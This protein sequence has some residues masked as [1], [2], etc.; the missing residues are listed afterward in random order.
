MRD[1]AP[2]GRRRAALTS[3]QLTAS[4][5]ALTCSCTFAQ[6]FGP[7]ACSLEPGTKACVDATPCKTDTSG[8]QICLSTVTSPPS[9]ALTIAQT[10]WQYG[11]TFA[12]AST[13][14]DTCKPY[15]T[16]PACSVISSIC[17]DHMVPSG[18]CDSW[19]FTYQCETAPGPTS[20]TTTCTTGLFDSSGFAALPKTNNNMPSAAVAEEMIREGQLYSDKGSNLFAGVS[21]TCRKGYGGL[22]SCCKSAPGAKTN[23]QVSEVAFGAAAQ[24]VKYLGE[25]AIDWASP[26]VLDSMYNNG[27]WIAGMTE[28]FQTGGDTFGTSLASSGFSVGAYGFSY[29]TV[30]TAGS[31]LLDANTTLL[32]GPDTGFLEFNPYVFAA[33]VAIMVIE[34]L[35]S[36]NN[37]EQLLAQHKGADLSV[38]EDETCTSSLLGSCVEYTDRY[39]SFNSVLAKI[40]DV[41]GKAQLGLSSK[42]CSGMSLAQL[43]SIDFSKIDFSEFTT[44]LSVQASAHTPSSSTISS[45]YGPAMA[46]KTGGSAQTRTL[47]TGSSVVGAATGPTLPPNA[48]LPQYPASA[49]GP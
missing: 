3:L 6:S 29:S 36:C 9:G 42:D 22:K 28:A 49:P 4:V 35:S 31:G 13:S 25:E 21:E 27:V 26:Y 46:T 8:Q 15:E 38:Y 19:T 34:D 43:S 10:C 12:C 41:Q 48:V 5:A 24:S 11:Y 2:I 7:G 33:M 37:E 32:G 40:I 20:T 30:D 14:S 47:T 1:T 18:I 39:C 23:S 45:A 16:N 44:S 17:E